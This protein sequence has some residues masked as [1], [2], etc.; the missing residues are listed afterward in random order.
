[1]H[2]LKRGQSFLFFESIILKC[3]FQLNGERTISSVFHLLNGSKSIQTIQ[4]V[5]NYQLNMF[6]GVYRH[7]NRNPFNQSVSFLL[8]NEY[9][10]ASEGEV[11]TFQLTEKALPFLAQSEQQFPFEYFNGLRY[12]ETAD[13]FYL[14]LLLL[15][16]TLTNT[17]MKFY[18]FIPITDQ[19][20]VEQWVKQIY[21]KLKTNETHALQG[22]YQEL[23]QLL[24]IFP[25]NF[26]SLFV[27]RLTG[28]KTYGKSLN[29]LAEL[30]M[31]SI[32]DVNLILTGIIHKIIA[33]IEE[34]RKEFPV[35]SFLL[36]DL[37]E[38]IPITNSTNQT[39]QLL[40]K[41][42]TLD[43]IA[44]MRN[45]KINTIHDHIVEI[46]LY[47]PLFSLDQYITKERQQ[48]IINVVNRRSTFKLRD[49]KNAVHDDISYFE[50][51]LV[52]AATKN[53]STGR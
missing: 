2:L 7:L 5:H 4:D 47:D 26:A 6:Y 45:L 39:Y 50:I 48:Q 22:I 40:Q 53:K 49:I 20:S 33:I 23:Y 25:N 9:I 44:L 8:K 35:L 3:L 31:L 11:N 32:A 37:T 38:K 27:D 52:L 28:Y 24:E 18:H 51:R 29:Q 43:Q 13:V 17:K 21:R 10:H 42:Y 46:A 16:Q 34:K 1:M 12:N 14:R 41:K 36:G 15:I 19:P 30:N